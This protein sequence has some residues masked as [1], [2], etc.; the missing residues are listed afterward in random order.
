VYSC[1]KDCRLT[2]VTLQTEGVNE[3]WTIFAT[4]FEGLDLVQNDQQKLTSKMV[5]PTIQLKAGQ[6]V[7]FT[8]AY[9][10][11]SDAPRAIPYIID[12]FMDFKNGR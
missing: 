10:G 8:G 9:K 7:V 5:Y 6:K 12:F 1:S 3:G 4:I 2:D 11:S